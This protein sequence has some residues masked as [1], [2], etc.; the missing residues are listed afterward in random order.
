M[1]RS[2]DQKAQTRRRILA[3]AVRRLREGGPRSVHVAQIMHDAG[4]THGGFYA[5]FPS[6][7][8]L[9]SEAVAQM[10]AESDILPRL[11]QGG[12][13]AHALS[14]F[15]GHYLSIGYCERRPGACPLPILLPQVDE[16]AP[17]ARAALLR[18]ASRLTEALGDIL[19][20]LGRSPPHAH[21]T[22]LLA[23]AIG[24]IALARAQP[25][26]A[27]RVSQLARA[28]QEVLAAYG[29]AGPA[30]LPDRPAMAPGR[31]SEAYPTA[32][33]GYARSSVAGGGAWSDVASVAAHAPSPSAALRVDGRRAPQPRNEDK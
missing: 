3:E 18:L 11:S 28:R 10:V 26:R 30:C 23:E 16:L 8:A 14:M 1:R 33:S 24:M 7:E 27:M 9:L 25:K 21:A 13:P 4:L 22:R 2:A 17:E 32:S 29:A 19:S 12:G 31:R 15:L 5:H 20:G 6:R